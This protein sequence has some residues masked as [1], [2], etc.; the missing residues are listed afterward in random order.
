[1]E[2]VGIPSSVE[3]ENNIL[4]L[5]QYIWYCVSK[6]NKNNEANYYIKKTTVR[7]VK[8]I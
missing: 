5:F 1:M 7:M 4:K 2:M 6:G 8:Q 3:K